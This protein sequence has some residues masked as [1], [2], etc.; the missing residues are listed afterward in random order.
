[1][2][3]FYKIGMKNYNNDETAITA[4][5]VALTET[6][7]SFSTVAFNFNATGDNRVAENLLGPR[8]LFTL[9][10]GQKFRL[11][12]SNPTPNS[13]FRQYAI[14]ATHVG[15]D[16]NDYYIKGT[17]NGQQS[18]QAC[19]DFLTKGSP[20]KYQLDSQFSN[21]DFGDNTIGGSHGDDVLNSI[22]EAF[23]C[24]WWFDNYTLHVAKTIG[25][26]EAFVFVDRV[27]ASHIAWNEDYSDFRTA[28]HGTGKPVEK[29]ETDDSGGSSSG[30]NGSVAAFARQYAG[31]P[32][33]WGRNSP[34]GW[35]CSGF[36][37][38]IYNHFGI[39]MHQPTTYEEYQGQ[40]VGP[41]YQEG[42]M[43][44]WGARG[45]TYHVALALD[46]STLEMAANPSQGT[47]VQSISAWPPAFGVRNAA[48]AAKVAGGS[49]DSSD[50]TSATVDQPEQYT[51]EADYLS[52]WA[53]KPGIGKIWADDFSSDSITD[54]TALKEA[55]K[56]QLHD[57][58]DVQYTV[59]WI[60]FERSVTDMPNEIQVGD[61]G[62]LR[63]RLGTDI[64]VRIQSY[65]RYLDSADPSNADSITFG[66]KI[67]DA[68]LY[69]SRQAQADDVRKQLEQLTQRSAGQAISYTIP[70]MTGEEVQRVNDYFSGQ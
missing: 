70:A 35:D 66:N 7:N 22:A 61:N 39:P 46:S 19:L 36:V 50:A 4:Y 60:D 58:P 34:S 15:H 69:D 42:D 57:Y 54:E 67:F 40:V 12:T 18:I 6:L 21:H 13:R 51:C 29:Q 64:N 37:A 33:V 43:L 44:F 1:M 32:Y 63:D 59:D 56:A 30:G 20:F 65:T 53:S 28:V 11:T 45:G 27:N 25:K 16:L 31:V 17:L 23:A 2:A 41:P 55:M 48:M 68:T 24:E 3:S 8:T 14:T 5:G 26:N 9:E 47:I 10:N 62:W 49:D 38:Y 52:P